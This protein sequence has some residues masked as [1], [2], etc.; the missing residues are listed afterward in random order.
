MPFRLRDPFRRPRGR[1]DAKDVA[2]ILKVD[3]AFLSDPEPAK[4]PG[5][6]LP[7]LSSLGRRADHAVMIRRVEDEVAARPRGITEGPVVVDIRLQ[8]ERKEEC[9]GREEDSHG[10]SLAG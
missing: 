8:R 7:D 9:Q 10:R 3:D 2:S 5:L 1:L 4:I 6:P